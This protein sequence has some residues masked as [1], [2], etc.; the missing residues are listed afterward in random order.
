MHDESNSS[1][2]GPKIQKEKETVEKFIRLYCEKK[3]RSS[4]KTLCSECQN[5]LEYSL[6][7]LEQCQYQEDKPTCRKCPVH[8]YRPTMREEIRRVMRFSGPRFVLHA[9]M[10]WIR[11]Q[12]HDREDVNLEI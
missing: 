7:R 12:L 8:C 4:S 1:N 6:L 2:I 5:L 10:D 9:P 3:H 11:H